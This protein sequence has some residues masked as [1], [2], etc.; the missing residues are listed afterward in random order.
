MDF[1]D[2]KANVNDII[3]EYGF[4][5]DKL[6]LTKCDKSYFHP[7]KSA[8]IK[9]GKVEIGSYGELHPK[10]AKLYDIKEK[11]YAFELMPN[12]IP[13]KLKQ[14][15]LYAP[16]IYQAISRDF[17]FILDEKIEA[18]DIIRTIKATNKDLIVSID[19]FDIYQSDKLGVDKKSVTI[20]VVLQ[21]CDHTFTEVEI[22]LISNKIINEVNNKF[23]GVIRS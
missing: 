12:F 13:L 10:I 19:I 14:Q 17:S 1:Y 23:G 21:A 9:I 2:I 11:I 16:S 15:Q 6:I 18:Q 8:T 20:N 3:S 4:D 5:P 7:G 22:D